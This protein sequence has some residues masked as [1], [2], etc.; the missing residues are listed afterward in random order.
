MVGE[1][2]AAALSAAKAEV[3]AFYKRE[4]PAFKEKLRRAKIRSEA[5]AIYLDFTRKT[6]FINF[7]LP[8]RTMEEVRPALR[9][10]IL[11]QQSTSLKSLM[12]YYSKR[13]DEL[14][15]QEYGK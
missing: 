2:R 5:Q 3:D 9:E 14:L 12:D 15:K 4:G 8:D 13:Y 6:Q 1:A 7:E 10:Y 11:E